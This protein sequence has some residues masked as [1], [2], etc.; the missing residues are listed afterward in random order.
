MRCIRPIADGIILVRQNKP[1]EIIEGG[2]ILSADL[3]GDSFE[4]IVHSIGKDVTNVKVGD[5]VMIA[6]Y[7]A[8]ETKFEEK[9]YMIVKSK[10]ILAIV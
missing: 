8:D 3:A 6:K 5:T 4:F 7:N 10:D 2:I 9:S 1:K